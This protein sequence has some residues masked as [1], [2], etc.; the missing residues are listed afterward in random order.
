MA[1]TDDYIY[2]S[3]S[4]TTG[5]EEPDQSSSRID[6]VAIIAS[7][8]SL[9]N[10]DAMSPPTRSD[11]KSANPNHLRSDDAPALVDSP[12]TKAPVPEEFKD[13]ITAN[14]STVTSAGISSK[15]VATSPFVEQG[16]G[17]Y[18]TIIANSNISH[19]ASTLEVATAQD[20]NCNEE[21][22]AIQLKVGAAHTSDGV[23]KVVEFYFN[24]NK[25]E[26]EVGE[27]SLVTF[28]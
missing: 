12:P 25:E 24:Y 26:P 20:D 23:E 6:P 15:E 7:E 19:Y 22:V 17:F 28:T 13:N 14:P 8:S 1:V 5:L 4:H 21:E 16:G 27:A 3:D 11:I 2:S 9:G 10:G 18:S